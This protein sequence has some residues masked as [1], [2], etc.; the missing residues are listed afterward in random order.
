MCVCV[1]GELL[2]VDVLGEL[3]RALTILVPSVVSLLWIFDFF[4]LVVFPDK[5]RVAALGCFLHCPWSFMLHLYR[6]FG[7]NGWIRTLLY[8]SF[9]HLHCLLQNY[10][11]DMQLKLVPLLYRRSYIFGR[12]T[13]FYILM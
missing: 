5:T 3:L 2:R 8:N 9:I 4:G 12:L 13:H 11:F 6:A 10:A 1:L 7:I